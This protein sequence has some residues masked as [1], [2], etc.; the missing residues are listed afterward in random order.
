MKFLAC[1]SGRG[2]NH[3]RRRSFPPLPHKGAQN[4]AFGYSP[5]PLPWLRCPLVSSFGVAKEIGVNS[6][7]QGGKRGQETSAFEMVLAP[8]YARKVTFA[9]GHS[10]GCPEKQKPP[11]CR[12][13]PGCGDTARFHPRFSL[14]ENMNFY[15]KAVTAGTPHAASRC[16]HSTPYRRHSSLRGL[17]WDVVRYNIVYRDF[18]ALS[19]GWRAP[20]ARPFKTARQRGTFFKSSSPPLYLFF[21]SWYNYFWRIIP[22]GAPPQAT[23]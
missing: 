22:R 5:T 16:A 17:R 11:H 7:P 20:N 14:I 9:A 4:R 8:S 3:L 13:S 6:Y 2:R 1:A 10:G 19:R 21:F 23:I 12:S 18:S 15:G